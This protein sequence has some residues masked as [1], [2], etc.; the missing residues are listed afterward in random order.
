MHRKTAGADTKSSI[1]VG[2][3][4][5][6]NNNV[7]A[8]MDQEGR[9]VRTQRLNNQLP[10]V[11]KLLKCYAERV[12]GIVVESTYNGYWLIDGLQDA[13]FRVHLA[14]S[15]GVAKHRDTK[16]A[17]DETDALLLAELLRQGRLPEGYMYPREQR[18]LRDLLRRRMLL[19]QNQTSLLLSLQSLMLRECCMPLTGNDLKRMPEEDLLRFVT[20]PYVQIQVRSLYGGLRAMQAAVA[21]IET[22]TAACRKEDRIVLRLM[23]IPGVGLV[24]ASIIRME[25]GDVSRFAGVGDFV[26]YCRLAPSAHYSNGHKKGEGNRKCGNR[27]LAWAFLE[28]AQFCRRY[29]PEARRY[30]ERKKRG[31]RAFAT[32]VASKALASKLARSA[33]VMLRHEQDFDPAR[34]FGFKADAGRK[35]GAGVA[36]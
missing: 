12:V 13:G 30:Y 7:V 33:Y 22:Q 27:Y 20:D 5:H 31:T 21:Q 9:R 32:A 1:Y 3:D 34:A 23:S 2:I 18:G 28:A 26:S 25:M 19:V 4:L 11:L 29:C 24:L 10:E 16:H 6:S 15:P 8:I 35:A 36:A 17:N 14:H